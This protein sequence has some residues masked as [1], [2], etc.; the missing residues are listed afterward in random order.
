MGPTWG[1]QDPGGTHVGPTNFAICNGL[2]LISVNQLVHGTFMWP[3][4]ND[5]SRSFPMCNNRVKMRHVFVTAR[6]DN[7]SSNS[8]LCNHQRTLFTNKNQSWLLVRYIIISIVFCGMWLFIH[9]ITSTVAKVKGYVRNYTPQDL[10]KWNKFSMRKTQCRFSQSLLVKAKVVCC[11]EFHCIYSMHTS[12]LSN[13]DSVLL[14]TITRTYFCN[15][16]VDV[17]L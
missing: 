3:T 14:V 9:A 6:H 15:S 16:L 5:I 4:S 12:K 11:Q 8:W 10:Y 7:S 13:M 1:R 17:S 2:K